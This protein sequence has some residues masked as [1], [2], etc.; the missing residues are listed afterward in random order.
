MITVIE[1][2]TTAVVVERPTPT[3]PPSVFNPL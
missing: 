3:V 1:A 2:M